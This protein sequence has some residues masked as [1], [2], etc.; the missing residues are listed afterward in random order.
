MK[1]F[2]DLS[3]EDQRFHPTTFTKNRERLL[4]ADAARVLLKEARRCRLPSAEH[5]TVGDT[6]LNA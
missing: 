6:L 1:W 5:L 4:E 2:L 3:V